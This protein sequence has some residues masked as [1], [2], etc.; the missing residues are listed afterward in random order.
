MEQETKYT[1]PDE[2]TADSIWEE[3]LAGNFGETVQ[4][5]TVKMLAVY[6]DTADQVL[7]NNNVTLRV[8]KENELAFA[9]IKWGGQPVL[10]GL[11]SHQEINIP[12]GESENVEDIPREVFEQSLDGK[13]MQTLLEG[14]ELLP[15]VQTDI[16][17]RRV[18]LYTGSGVAEL[19][20]DRGTVIGGDKSAPV[21]EL[22]VELYAGAL[23]DVLELTEHIAKKYGLVPENR[24]KYARAIALLQE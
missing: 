17:R 13:Q 5:E 2:A 20:V 4:P 23:E 15:L 14:K 1:I 21:S 18:K 6:Y 12:L 16:T 9:T 22:E 11:F 24:S 19:S 3:A 8:R 10:D 7:R